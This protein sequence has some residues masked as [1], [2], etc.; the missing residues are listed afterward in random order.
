M[1]KLAVKCE[2]VAVLDVMLKEYY[3]FHHRPRQTGSINFRHSQCR[4][5]NDNSM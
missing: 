1:L 4:N 3:A 2:L 5:R